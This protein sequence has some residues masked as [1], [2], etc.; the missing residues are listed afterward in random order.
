MITRPPLPDTLTPAEHA[1]LDGDP[2][3]AERLEV[4]DALQWV[5]RIVADERIQDAEEM[6]QSFGCMARPLYDEILDHASRMCGLVEHYRRFAE[7]PRESF[8]DKA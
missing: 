3:L 2:K 1:D 5:C 6:L 8:S 7:P 4:A